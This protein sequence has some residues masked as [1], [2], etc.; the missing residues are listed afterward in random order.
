LNLP[1]VPYEGRMSYCLVKCLQMVLAYQGH[2]YSLPWLECVSG[3]A[4]EFIYVRDRKRFFPIIG[5][6]Y[7]ISGENLLS[8]LNFDYTYTGSK[9][10]GEA[11]AALE[12]ALK[13][14]P[15]A[16]GMLDMGY[17]TYSPFH[18]MAKGAD[19]AVVVLG[20]EADRVV[21]HDP[22]GFVAVPLPLADFLEAWQRDVYTG[23]PYGLWQ[24]GPQG[25]PPTDE[26]IWERTLTRARSNLSQTEL[27]L[28][29]ARLLYGP[30]GMR[31]LARDLSDWPEMD[32][33]ALPLFNWRVSAQRCLDSAFFIREKLPEAASLRWEECQIYGRLQQASATGKRDALPG[34][35]ENLAECE[36]RFIKGMKDEG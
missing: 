1:M 34:L 27:S 16:V 12:E 5:D 28:G 32:L 24:I 25:T 11:L 21:V 29:D 30:A 6:R 23:K 33:G 26:E 17:L 10:D 13:K 20:L 22:D 36:T 7:H 4:F 18:K 3:S 15:V 8:T 31:Q 19:H 2:T 14:G 35:L 9:N